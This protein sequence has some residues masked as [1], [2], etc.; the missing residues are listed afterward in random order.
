MS[1]LQFFLHL[2][3]LRPRL[4]SIARQKNHYP[5]DIHHSS[6]IWSNRQIII[7]V[8]RTECDRD[9]RADRISDALAM[10]C[11][12]WHKLGHLLCYMGHGW[13]RDSHLGGDGYNKEQPACSVKRARAHIN[14]QQYP[15]WAG[16]TIQLLTVRQ[17]QSGAATMATT[18]PTTSTDLARNQLNIIAVIIIRFS[19]IAL[20]GSVHQ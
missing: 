6:Q 7:E 1:K 8:T 17:W 15:G 10:Q 11:I 20:T 4:H 3:L 13:Q 9:R 2:W 18:A 19:F 12:T 14:S 5:P 16:T